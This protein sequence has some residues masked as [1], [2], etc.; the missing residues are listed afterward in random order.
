MAQMPGKKLYKMELFGSIVAFAEK[1]SR[2]DDFTFFLINLILGKLYL[3]FQNS[4]Y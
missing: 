4:F 3:H 1:R 2:N